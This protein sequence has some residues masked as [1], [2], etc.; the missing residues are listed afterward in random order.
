MVANHSGDLVTVDMSVI[1]VDYYRTF[2]YDR[3]LYALAH[4]YHQLEGTNV[5]RGGTFVGSDRPRRSIAWIAVTGRGLCSGIAGSFGA[6]A[7][8]AGATR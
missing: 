5:T 7:L 4:G 2:G 1:A 8:Q 6:R 3:P